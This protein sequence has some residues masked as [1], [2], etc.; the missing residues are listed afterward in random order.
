MVGP[1]RLARSSKGRDLVNIRSKGIELE[2]DKKLTEA[3][4]TRK[5]LRNKNYLITI[6]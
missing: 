2:S 5:F 3:F 6:S 1:E 4:M